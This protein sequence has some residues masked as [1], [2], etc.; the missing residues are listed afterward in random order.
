M[1]INSLADYNTW[2]QAI[3]K[4]RPLDGKK[5]LICCETGCRAAG[6]LQVAEQ[7]EKLI[8]E[9]K[10]PVGVERVVK[11]TGCQGMCEK[12]PIVWIMPESIFYCSVKEQDVQ[13]IFEKTILKGEIVERLLYKDIDSKCSCKHHLDIDFFKKQQLVILKKM[14]QMDPTDIQDYIRFGGYK[15]LVEVLT[16]QNPEYVMQQIEQS[17]L[18]GRGGGGFNVGRK[19]RSCKAVEGPRYVLCN[20]DEGDPGAFMDRS[21]MEGDPHAIIEGMVLGA[22]AVESNKGYLYVRHEYPL[23]IEHLTIAIKQAEECGFLGDN[24][25]GTDFSFHLSINRGG[26]AF[27]CGESSALMRSIEGKVGEPR[28]KYIHSTEKGL[29]DKPTV[30]NNVETWANIP[31][32]LRDGAENFRKI[33]TVKSPGT[34]VFS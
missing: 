23:A 14:G 29:F 10:I 15:T 7:L 11:K 19:W 28:A 6:S 5:V 25:A 20:G 34:K 26:G 33:G 18:R 1:K 9:N 4:D 27:V 24:I 3:L 21:I 13:E 31:V 32:I 17:G 16:T 30:L 2:Q 22:F 8:K 12:G